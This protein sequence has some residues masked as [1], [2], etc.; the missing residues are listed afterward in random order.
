M[1]PKI[2]LSN[3]ANRSDFFSVGDRVSMKNGGYYPPA[4]KR[5]PREVNGSPTC[6]FFSTSN[7]AVSKKAAQAVGNHF[8]SEMTGEDLDFSLRI[9]NA[10][11]K[12]FFRPSAVVKHLHRTSLRQLCRRVSAD[13]A[14]HSLAL[15]THARRVLEFRLQLWG[16]YSLVIPFP[17]QSMIYWGDFHFM[18]LF[19]LWALFKT[20]I[21]LHSGIVWEKDVLLLWGIFFFFFLKYFIP[22]LKI[23][24]ASNFPLWAWI[25]Y[26]TNLA[27]LL[28]GLKGSLKYKRLNI[29]L[30]W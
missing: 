24:P 12:L 26:R 19:G 25:R 27:L 20:L 9:S 15:K 3:I 30:S 14:C 28:G 23:Q 4:K 2:K 17:I 1:I 16:E 6:P 5:Y 13:G 18:H 10:G 7:A 21:T 22:V 29:E 11:Y 8:W